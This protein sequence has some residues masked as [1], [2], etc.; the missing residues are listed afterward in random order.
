MW[1]QKRPRRQGCRITKIE[2][3]KLWCDD[4]GTRRRRG[5]STGTAPTATSCARATRPTRPAPR[6]RLRAEPE[7]LRDDGRPARRRR[8]HLHRRRSRLLLRRRRP[9]VPDRLLGRRAASPA[10]SRSSRSRSATR[11][12]ATTAIRRRRHGGAD[13]DIETGQDPTALCLAV[14]LDFQKTGAERVGLSDL[15]S[16]DFD[17][18]SR[19][20]GDANIDV[21]FR[22]GLNVN[23][24]AGFPSVLGKFH[25]YWGF[26]ATPSR[27]PR[28]RLARRR[29]RRRST[30]TPASSSA[31]S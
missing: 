12:P 9:G 31:S 23:Q 1:L 3:H 19:L 18:G 24:S 20:R 4:F 21:R 10:S 30:S 8:L 25:L 7:R 15:I 22:T 6:R 2:T 17:I 16:G 27:R 29:L 26:E 13:G 14:G 28:L 11:P 5:R